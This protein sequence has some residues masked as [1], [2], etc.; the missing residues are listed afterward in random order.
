MVYL[1]RLLLRLRAWR[2]SRQVS[3]AIPLIVPAA[4]PLLR[5]VSS[6][7]VRV[8]S[9]C[10]GCGARLECSATLCAACAQRRSPSSF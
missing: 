8:Y 10:G 6:A 7:G 3:A 1:Q 9:L 4:Q 2:T 5:E